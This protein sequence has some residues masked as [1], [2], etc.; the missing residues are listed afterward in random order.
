MKA[1]NPR[2]P[3]F[4]LDPYAYLQPYRDQ[5]PIHWSDTI[6]MWLL[7][8]YDDVKM[9]FQ[10]KRFGRGPEFHRLV[11]RPGE[12]LLPVE[13]MRH[14]F[15]LFR[16]PP[17]HTRLRGLVSRAFT[18]RL[19]ENLSER[20][21]A[22]TDHLLDRVQERGEIEIISMLAYPLAVAVIADML[23]IPLKDQELLGQ[24][25]ADA[26]SFVEVKPTEEDITRANQLVATMTDYFL[27]LF[28]E[29]RKNPQNDLISQLIALEAEGDHLS[30]E[31]LL[32]T[33]GLLLFAGHETTANMIGNG[34]LTLLQ[35]PT[36]MKQLNDDPSLLTS[37]VT[38]LLR[39]STSVQALFRIALE[40]VQMGDHT[41]L[42]GQKTM[43][44]VIAANRDPRR[45]ADPDQLDIHRQSNQPL[46]F[47]HGIHYCLGAP[48]AM[49]EMQIAIATMMRRLP[50]LTLQ[51]EQ[52]DWRPSLTIRGLQR[53]PLSF[54]VQRVYA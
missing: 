53:L 36:Q 5:D 6:N 14:N 42:A 32:G 22:I 41:I 47:G 26:A 37:T 31:E 35:H 27:E 13:R 54:E 49:L 19:V 30:E 18:P 11:T 43:G 45:F 17:D 2:N 28:A 1:F 4:H 29:K 38:E 23:G 21:Q 34:I 46:S 51:T 25:A 52:P 10:D 7:T 48:L 39:Y 24:Y 9:M 12:P 20:I 16:D 50:N 44:A 3:A 33:C 8:R 40:D 15:F